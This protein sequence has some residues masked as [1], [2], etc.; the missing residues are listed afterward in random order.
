MLRPI[1]GCGHACARRTQGRPRPAPGAAGSDPDQARDFRDQRCGGLRRHRQAARPQH[2]RSIA[3]GP[4][5]G[6]MGR[7]GRAARTGHSPPPT[8]HHDRWRT[9]PRPTSATRSRPAEPRW[10]DPGKAFRHAGE[11]CHLRDDGPRQRADHHRA[12]H[13]QE[14][15]QLPQQ[16]AQAGQGQGDEHPQGVGNEARKWNGGHRRAGMIT[17]LTAGAARDRE[18]GSDRPCS[19]P[20]FAAPSPCR[21]RWPRPLAGRPQ[22]LLEERCVHRARS[23]PSK[24]DRCCLTAGSRFQAR[25]HASLR[26]WRTA[27]DSR[28]AHSFRTAY[29]DRE[30]A[31][32]IGWSARC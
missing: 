24:A 1:P 30:Y 7:P 17:C 21:G 27:R 20:V 9:S 32:G 26:T 14:P 23:N 28:C 6:G 4:G 15:G 22:G 5:R 8:T 19:A 3:A 18:P 16:H 10:S 2:R 11:A 31:P 25:R 13:Q 12:E 29:S